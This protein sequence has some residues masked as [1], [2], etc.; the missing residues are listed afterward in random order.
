MMRS[1]P[2]LTRL[3]GNDLQ[4]AVLNATGSDEALPRD[5]YIEAILRKLHDGDVKELRMLV[6]Y[7]DKRLKEKNWVIVL[8]TLLVIRKLLV[9]QDRNIARSISSSS[10]LLDI[11]E[12]CDESSRL[13]VKKSIILEQYAAYLHQMASAMLYVGVGPDHWDSLTAREIRRFPLPDL[14]EKAKKLQLAMS[15]LLKCQFEEITLKTPQQMRTEGDLMMSLFLISLKDLL[16][17]YSVLEEIRLVLL[18]GFFKTNKSDART[19]LTIL[20]TFDDST[21]SLASLCQMVRSF[22]SDYAEA[23]PEIKPVSHTL[24][25]TLRGH[26]DSLEEVEDPEKVPVADLTS[27]LS[28][29]EFPLQKLHV[30][31]TNN[32]ETDFFQTQQNT[33]QTSNTQFQNNSTNNKETNFFS[34]FFDQSTTITTPTTTTTTTPS[35]PSTPTTRPPSSTLPP[36]ILPP[37]I[38]NSPTKVTA[39]SP[40]TVLPPIIPV[41][42]TTRLSSAST[43]QSQQSPQSPSQET[44]NSFQSRRAMFEARSK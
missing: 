40:P 5:I 3:V 35:T 11:N 18:D 37:P 14:H 10:I 42:E 4:K 25:S 12:K 41:N 31:T 34:D 23:L 43:T 30:D 22:S 29:E 20:T 24:F 26:V 27:L 6:D 39:S 21:H 36:T 9:D 16:G 13:G 33:Q 1:I 17:L 19:A 44:G 2:S 32:Q 15:A 7:L 8:K 28:K 38:P